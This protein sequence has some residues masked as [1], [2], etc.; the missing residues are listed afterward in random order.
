MYII[1]HTPPVPSSHI[2]I[3][4]FRAT[5]RACRPSV[6]PF[7]PVGTTRPSRKRQFAGHYAL[8]FSVRILRYPEK[9]PISI[10]A[11]E[12]GGRAG[13]LRQNVDE[14]N[15]RTG[16]LGVGDMSCRSIL[17]DIFAYSTECPLR[18]LPHFSF[19]P[20]LRP[21]TNRA[22]VPRYHFPRARD[23]GSA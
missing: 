14:S 6:L 11:F 19:R 5:L 17:C 3:F 22:W 12:S 8:P 20:R 13:R 15:K 1:S 18:F 10:I 4:P 2:P 21:G 9:L 23:Y 7:G 16:L